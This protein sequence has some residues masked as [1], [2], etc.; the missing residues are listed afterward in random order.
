MTLD[1]WQKTLS[2]KVSGTWNL[3]ETLTSK[4]TDSSLDFFIMF[5]SMASIIGNPGQSNYAAGNSYQDAL[6]R[7]LSSQGHNV[8]SLNVPMMSDAG[9]VATKPMLK[10]YLLSIGWSHMSVDELI[11]ALDYYCRPLGENKDMTAKQ[12]Q[13]VPRLWLPKYTATIGAVQPTWQHEPRFNHM[14]LHSTNSGSYIPTTKQD[15]G[16]GLTAALLS[17]AKLPQAAEQIV[18]DALLEKLTKV[19]NVN[20]AELDPSKPMYAYGVD[21]LVAVELRTW[22]A[23]E[24]GSEVSVFEITSGVPIRQL[25]IKVAGTSRFVQVPIGK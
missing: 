5:S 13:V 2:I 24:I 4:N 20:M 3:W 12:A 18:L 15:F 23:K 10:E 6:A 25:A 19:L 1:R 14:V 8:V 9:M 16:K 22:I 11:A 21:S 17:A 7:R